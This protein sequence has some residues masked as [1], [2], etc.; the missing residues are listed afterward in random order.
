M[1]GYHGERDLPFPQFLPHPSP[2]LSWPWV[3]EDIQ[4]QQDALLIAARVPW[5]TPSHH[6]PSAHR[7][8]HLFSL[9]ISDKGAGKAAV[10][11]Y[12]LSRASLFPH[13]VE[14]SVPDC[15]AQRWALSI[16]RS[17]RVNDKRI[18]RYCDNCRLIHTSVSTLTGAEMSPT[19]NC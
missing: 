2:G 11:S 10:L 1:P 3:P 9:H 19:E 5:A 17:H 14:W 7:V 15:P 13:G 16:P 8:S 6:G 4:G 12:C 18:P